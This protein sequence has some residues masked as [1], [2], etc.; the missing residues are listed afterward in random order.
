MYITKDTIKGLCKQ[1]GMTFKELAIKA[2]MNEKSLHNKFQRDSI[3][4][5]D[6]EKLLSCLGYTLSIYK[7][8]EHKT[9]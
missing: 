8:P 3:T 2:G 5:R 9:R 4:L 6:I 7:T 1:E